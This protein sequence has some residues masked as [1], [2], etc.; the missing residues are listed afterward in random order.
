MLNIW[1]SV[2]KAGSKIYDFYSCLM[3]MLN[4]STF[5]LLYSHDFSYPKTHVTVLPKSSFTIMLIL[6]SPPDLLLFVF[7]GSFCVL[8]Q[9]K[10]IIAHFFLEKRKDLR[11]EVRIASPCWWLPKALKYS[12]DWNKHNTKQ[13]LQK[14]VFNLRNKSAPK[15]KVDISSCRKYSR[16][17][18]LFLFFIL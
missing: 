15:L 9:H 18:C 10:Q 16:N 13:Q 14:N 1:F 8:F 12:S 4:D 17:F 2:I 5:S 7:G 11:F 6:N 3:L